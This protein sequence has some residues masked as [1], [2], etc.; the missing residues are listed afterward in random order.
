ME[1]G[2][3]KTFTSKRNIKV[4]LLR[5]SEN[6]NIFEC[7]PFS[8]VT[9]KKNMRA[10]VTLWSAEVKIQ[11]IDLQESGEQNGNNADNEVTSCPK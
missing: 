5:A 11:T 4:N 7:T 3:F 1:Q 2:C 10:E 6:L 9:R 8:E